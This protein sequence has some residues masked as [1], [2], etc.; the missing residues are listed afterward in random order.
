MRNELKITVQEKQT[1][2]DIAK[3]EYGNLECIKQLILDNPTVITGLDTILTPG[4]TLNIQKDKTKV[5]GF[6]AEV[7]KYFQERG[8]QP[9]GEGAYVPALPQG[10]Q[11]WYKGY[12]ARSLTTENFKNTIEVNGETPS[13]TGFKRL[14]DFSGNGLHLEQANQD[15]QPVLD[16]DLP[17]FVSAINGPAVIGVEVT[18]P[19]L[20]WAIGLFEIGTVY[21]NTKAIVVNVDSTNK[22]YPIV[23]DEITNRAGMSDGSTDVFSDVTDGGLFLVISKVTTSGNNH[24]VYVNG[25]EDVAVSSDKDFDADMI[26]IGTLTEG[27]HGKMHELAIYS[28]IDIS[29]EQISEIYDYFQ[30]Q[31]GIDFRTL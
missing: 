9:A 22:T 8:V 10:M 1:I 25:N 5:V 30:M 12:A 15:Y 28:G 27:F 16:G 21:T 19:R 2:W 24:K 4:S 26:C 17:L 3:Q 14:W 13:I 31:T 7:V 20:I 23:F 18:I 11:A 29:T 6:N